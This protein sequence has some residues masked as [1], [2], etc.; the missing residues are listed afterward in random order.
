MTANIF[1]FAIHADDVERA[2]RFYEA[3]FDWRFER[4]GPEGFYT[5]HTGD[6]DDPGIRG[7]LHERGEPLTGTGVRGFECTV[8]VT[9]LDRV[10]EA[11]IAN[12]GKVRHDVV[13]IPSIGTLTQFEDT[14][15]NLVT[16]M[17]YAD[18]AP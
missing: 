14:E 9:D 8:A 7:A 5:I 1:H 12:G 10:R 17:R 18:G 16:A 3:V 6:E 11:I 4:W 2:R 15:G 13:E